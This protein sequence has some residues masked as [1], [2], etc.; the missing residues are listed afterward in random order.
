MLLLLLLMMMREGKVA[1]A[2]FKIIMLL[3]ETCGCSERG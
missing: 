1:S 2:Q 3:G